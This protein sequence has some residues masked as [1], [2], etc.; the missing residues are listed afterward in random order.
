MVRPNVFPTH[1]QSFYKSTGENYEG[2]KGRAYQRA[3]R[4]ANKLWQAA[5][6]DF[7]AGDTQQTGAP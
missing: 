7:D 1:G 3:K 5:L 2:D 6:E 4:E